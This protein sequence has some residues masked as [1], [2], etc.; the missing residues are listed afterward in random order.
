[1]TWIVVT[2]IACRILQFLSDLRFP[3]KFKGLFLVGN[4]TFLSKIDLSVLTI[5]TS[6]FNH[7][8]SLIDPWL[9]LAFKIEAAV[10]LT[11]IGHL[12]PILNI[13]IFVALLEI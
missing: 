8:V 1:M 3:A 13:H 4:E 7:F 12:H 6:V 11:Y 5:L 9:R 10:N 2:L